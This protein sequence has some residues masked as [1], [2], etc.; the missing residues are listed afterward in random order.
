MGEWDKYV[1]ADFRLEFPAGSLVLDVGCGEGAQMRELIDAGCRAVG[2]DVSDE[3][4]AACRG[5]GLAVLKAPAENI[6]L[7][8]ASLDGI[9]C[10]VV[11]PY[12]WE[13]EAIAE[14]ARLLK[15]GG[16]AYFIGHGAG[17]YLNYLLLSRSP[18]LRIY[19][20]RSLANT[21]FHNLT[22]HRLPGFLGDT[23]YQSHRRLG[24]NYDR[25]SMEVREETASKKFMGFPVFI[26]QAVE[27]VA[28]IP[29]NSSK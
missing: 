27:K 20:L 25:G 18:M 15:P 26:Y 7:A 16:K 19:A 14:F 11:L 6:P 3:C 23:V 1:A 21:W 24:Q 12:L 29:T 22:G 8:D 9:V 17:Y 4:L 10:K 5:K 2:I 28:P 13:K